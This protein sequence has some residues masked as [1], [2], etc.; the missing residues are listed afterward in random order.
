MQCQIHKSS[1]GQFFV[2]VVARN[3]Q[4]LAHSENYVAKSSA[5][6]CATIIA[7][8]GEVRDLT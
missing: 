5:K 6:N 7:A 4:I 1:T 2:R 8:G 3:G